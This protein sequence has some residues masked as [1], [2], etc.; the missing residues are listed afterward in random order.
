MKRV[1]IAVITAVGF[2]A[3]SAAVAQSIKVGKNGKYQI[4]TPDGEVITLGADGSMEQAP[5]KFKRGAN[6]DLK[7]GATASK[8]PRTKG[9]AVACEANSDLLVEHRNIDAEPVAVTMTGNCDADVFNTHISA[10][11]HGIVATGTGELR[12]TDSIVQATEVAIQITGTGDVVLEGAQ[13]AGPIALNVTG[14][15]NVSAKNSK[16]YGKIVVTG[17]GRF[18]DEGGNE[19]VADHTKAVVDAAEAKPAKKTKKKSKK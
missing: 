15:G 7:L 17:T 13:L 3:T 11:K 4:T 1:V 8:E 9:I 19:L 10:A 18:I 5:D 6:N 2:L 12:V 16:I 14:T